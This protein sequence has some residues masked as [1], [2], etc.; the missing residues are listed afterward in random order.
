[1][2]TKQAQGVKALEQVKAWEGAAAVALGEAAFARAVVK[3]FPTN[4]DSLA[5]SN[6]APSAVR[7]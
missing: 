5:L 6:N 1:M 2:E 7:Q 4:W 3:K